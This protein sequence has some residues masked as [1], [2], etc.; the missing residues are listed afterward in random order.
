MIKTFDLFIKLYGRE[1]GRNIE[2]HNISRTAVKY[3]L[4]WHRKN[5]DFRRYYV[6]EHVRD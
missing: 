3:Y 6:E 5:P 2:Y 4:E 1:H